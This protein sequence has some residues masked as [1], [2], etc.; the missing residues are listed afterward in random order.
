MKVVDF[1]Q[2]WESWRVCACKLCYH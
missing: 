1:K 2:S